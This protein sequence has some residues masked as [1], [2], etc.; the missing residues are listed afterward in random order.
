MT[1]KDD[2]RVSTGSGDA[3]AQI[4]NTVSARRLLSR[5]AGF[6][7]VAAAF[8]ALTAF[9]TTPS[10]LYGLYKQRD[11]LSSI[12][13]T[14]AYAIYAAG[15]V[16]SL[17]LVGH[18][19]DWYGRKT[20]LIPAVLTALAAAVILT[21]S[22]SLPGLLI[23]RVVTGLALG[24]AVATAT[25]YL[26]DLGTSVKKA[27][28]V[29][30][31]ANIGGLALGALIAGVLARYVAHP[32]TV[33]YLVF[34][35]ALTAAVL[36]VIASPEGRPALRPSPRYRA[37]R[38][39]APAGAKAQFTAAIIGVFLAFAAF[40]LFA[41]LAGTLLAGPFHDMSEALTGL[42]IFLTFGSGVVVQTTTTS[43]SLRRLVSFGI[44]VTIVGLAVFASALWVTPPS[45][46]LFIVGGVLIGGG[47]GAIFRSTLTVTVSMS[48]PDDRAGALAT[49]FT[50]GYIG[51][52]LPVIGLGV[53]LQ[54]VSAKI[55]VLVFS[56]I[57]A[58]GILAAAPVL[59]KAR[60]A[61]PDSV[62]ANSESKPATTNESARD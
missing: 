18:V 55:T 54:Y 7:A 13:L 42:T 16:V 8:L 50:V 37:Q 61:P 49:F 6:W 48:P 25:A 59:L 29:G 43:W 4:R 27:G 58:A 62:P 39:K 40:G 33:P 51:L 12:T 23:G 45:L 60:V 34:I 3:R 9:S 53:A 41:G 11:G 30:T 21:A 28:I 57:V 2:A 46:T 17:L 22:K 14:I 26:T 56:A 52:S 19:S 47:G 20:V 1:D 35:A 31:V 38:L 5:Q 15:I 32:L 36:A 10:P 44:C 24:A